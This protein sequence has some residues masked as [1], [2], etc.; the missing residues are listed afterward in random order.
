MN[1]SATAAH[2]KHIRPR[3]GVGTARARVRLVRD[4]QSA[5][6]STDGPSHRPRAAAPESPEGA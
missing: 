3:K 6:V 5:L 1:S 2:L 4:L